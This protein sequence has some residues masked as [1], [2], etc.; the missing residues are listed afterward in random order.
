MTA[1]I[2]PH[3][4]RVPYVAKCSFCKEPKSDTLKVVDVREDDGTPTGTA[5][6]QN[7]AK[8][9]AEMIKEVA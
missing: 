5:I 8:T 2:I 1:E 3:T 9:F 6:C 4:G 7:C